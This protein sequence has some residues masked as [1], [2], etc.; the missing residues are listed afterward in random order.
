MEIEEEHYFELVRKANRYDDLLILYQKLLVK[1]AELQACI[2]RLEEY[3][4]VFVDKK[5]KR[6]Y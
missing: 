4:A 2:T 5:G 3:I 1:C 6:G